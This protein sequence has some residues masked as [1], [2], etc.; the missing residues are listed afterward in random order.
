MTEPRTTVLPLVDDQAAA[1]LHSYLNHA[2]QGAELAAAL[3]PAGETDPA[4][5]GRLLDDAAATLDAVGPAGVPGEVVE[6]AGRYWAGRVAD[7]G[8]ALAAEDDASSAAD[9]RTDLEIAQDHHQTLERLRS[10]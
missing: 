5:R 6:S 8:R 7:L 10:T 1:A 4:E 9:L 2:R 3:A